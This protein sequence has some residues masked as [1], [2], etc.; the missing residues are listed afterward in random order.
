MFIFLLEFTLVIF[1]LLRIS[2][3]LQNWSQS[4]KFDVRF[5]IGYKIPSKILYYIVD[6]KNVLTSVSN[7]LPYRAVCWLGEIHLKIKL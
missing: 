1:D 4:D 2:D 5:G 6:H 7:A 3:Y